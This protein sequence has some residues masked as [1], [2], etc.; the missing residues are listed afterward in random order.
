MIANAYPPPGSA[1]RLSLAVLGRWVRAALPA[2]LY[3]IRLWAAVC[4]ALFVAFQ[5]ELENP[6]WAGASAA[7]VCQPVLGAS[8]RKGWFRLVGT[9]IGA[10][11]AVVLSAC[12]P[13]NRA[14]FLLGLAF[15]G[16][17]CA[18]SATLL[19][20]FASYAAALAGYTAAIICGD[21]LGQVGG[22]NGDAFNLAVAR[23]TEISI[24][25]FC[26]GVV[27][28]LTDLGGAR[29]RLAMLLA[30]LSA[31]IGVGLTGALRQVGGPGSVTRR[32]DVRCFRA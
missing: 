7:I 19:R 4:L 14:A 21:E 26:G 9:V 11:A 23:G 3:G 16:G 12:F 25:I 30:E 22:V 29:Q 20:N 8:L 24:G 18:L 13:Q 31:A 27:L 28:A 32:C 2:L 17:V 6:S 5:L 10:V 1:G 15:W